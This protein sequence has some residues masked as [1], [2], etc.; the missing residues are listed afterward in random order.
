MLKLL[1]QWMRE[2]HRT[3]VFSQFTMVLDILEVVF[4]KE[5][6]VVLSPGRDNK[7]A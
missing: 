2:G 7:G 5:E 4:S 3:L 1:R 6:I